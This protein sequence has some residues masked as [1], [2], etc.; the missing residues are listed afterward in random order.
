MVTLIY[1]VVGA[2]LV[3]MALSGSVLKRLPLSTSLVYLAVG[4]GLGKMGDAWLAP[5]AHVHLLE[6][7]TEVAVIISLFCSGL[8]LRLPLSD[9]GWRLPLRLALGAMTV[10]VGLLTL[11]GVFGLGLSLG[12]ALLLGAVLAPTD[13]VLASDVQVENPTDTDRLRFGLTGEA[14]LNDGS[15]F[16]FVML[17]LGLLGHHELG[18]GGWR[19]FAVDLLWAVTGGLLIGWLLGSGVGRLVLYL[20]RTHQEAVGLD[21]LLALGLIA[22]S[23]GV[24]IWAHAY[25]FLAVFAAGLALRYREARAS[26]GQPPPEDVASVAKSNKPHEV[27]TH[28]EAAPA[29]MAQAVLGFTEQLE[30]MGEVTLMVLVG[31]M[32]ATVGFAA[33]GFVVAGLLFLL[34]RPLSVALLLAGTSTSPSQRALIGWFGIRGIGSLY[35]LFYALNHELGPTLG[36][37]LARLVL[38]V[39]ATS[40]VL[41]GISVTPLM[42]WY[43]RHRRPGP[44]R[45]PQP[46]TRTRSP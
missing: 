33:E 35:Y 11:V 9:R 46:E 42:H 26:R 29:Y 16:P 7:L 2:L 25:G 23:Y 28:P 4:A 32:L 24:A 15:A 40:A 13:P 12:A 17:G 22:L 10:T 34:I 18:A 41:H 43:S 44:E 3:L 27:A 37:P 20:R 1:L 39:V 38:T 5:L 6:R 21:D 19:W 31:V 45:Q 36:E 30:R 14:G 8:K